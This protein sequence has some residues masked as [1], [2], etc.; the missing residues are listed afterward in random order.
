MKRILLSICLLI[1]AVTACDEVNSQPELVPSDLL[2][3]WVHSFEEQVDRNADIMIFRPSD[4]RQFAPSWFRQAY[5]FME[6]GKCRYLV[7]H[8]LDAHYMASGTYS[9]D[10]ENDIIL[11]YSADGQL[12]QELTILVLN[13]DELSI[14]VTQVG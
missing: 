2:K 13:S 14:K 12:V 1:V 5:E 8:P 7:L 4:S 3:N 11:I 10:R 9:F 6:D